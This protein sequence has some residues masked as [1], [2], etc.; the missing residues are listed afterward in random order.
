MFDVAALIAKGI[1]AIAGFF[2]IKTDL[3]EKV[4]AAQATFENNI[5]AAAQALKDKIDEN[6]KT[7]NDTFT[8][9]VVG[10]AQKTIEA[11][12]ANLEA[13]NDMKAAAKT[14][15]DYSV[16]FGAMQPG[17]KKDAAPSFGVP[18]SGTGLTDTIIAN[19]SEGGM[20]NYTD[21]IKAGFVTQKD[22][23]TSYVGTGGSIPTTYSKGFDTVK[24][25]M[26]S[27]NLAMNLAAS[28]ISKAIDV[29]LSAASRAV[30]DAEKYARALRSL[31]AKRS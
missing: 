30:R 1:D 26:K 15:T 24:A 17:A 12:N 20:K 21:T 3:E 27:Y 13:A 22:I 5:D 25:S 28:G 19:I 10:A 9:W 23:T 14:Y 18:G 11:A 4:R 29:A 2:G 6:I 7:F 8:T 16:D 31:E